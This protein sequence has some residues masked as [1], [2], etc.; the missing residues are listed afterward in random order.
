MFRRTICAS[1]TAHLSKSAVRGSGSNSAL[2]KV[3]STCERLHQRTCHGQQYVRAAPTAHLSWSA[4]RASGSN[5]ALVMVSSTCERLQQHT[6]HSQQYV[7]AA[8]TAHLSWSAVRASGS[9]SALVM[10][11]S[12]CERPPV[13]LS[14]DGG[15]KTRRSIYEEATRTRKWIHS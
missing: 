5:S 14:R 11:S 7:R 10:V 9:N 2:V 12:T 3:S 15:G 13:L 8:P 6:C 4:V 1:P